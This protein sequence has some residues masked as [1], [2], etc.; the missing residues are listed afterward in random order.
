[1][2]AKL[3]IEGQINSAMRFLSRDISGGVLP[4]T[5]HVM[6]QLRE[7]HQKTQPAKLKVLFRRPVQDI[8][9]YFLQ[10]M[11][12]WCTIYTEYVDSYQKH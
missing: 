8:P 5:D 12:R 4:L 2:F 1:M 11:E 10:Q 9:D 3:M 7:K 6:L